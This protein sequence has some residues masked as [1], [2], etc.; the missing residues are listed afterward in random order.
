M[1]HLSDKEE[2]EKAGEVKIK[3]EFLNELKSLKLFFWGRANQSG[4]YG[5]FWH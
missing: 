4:C 1:R 2:F 5:S 3:L